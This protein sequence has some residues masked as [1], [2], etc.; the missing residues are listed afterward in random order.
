MYLPLT[1][2]THYIPRTR[3][4]PTSSCNVLDNY[5]RTALHYACAASNLAVVKALCAKT[6]KTLISR[7]D[8]NKR[9]VLHL[10]ASND[11]LGEVV[12]YLVKT[13]RL[14]VTQGDGK[15]LTPLHLACLAG[16]QVAVGTMLD[17][18][19]NTALVTSALNAADADGQ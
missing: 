18:L 17:A 10:A 13:E 7:P 19:G 16:L 14:A 6:T 9:T 2:L 8:V 1:P 12:H 11:I 5:G 4:Y 3:P 15:K